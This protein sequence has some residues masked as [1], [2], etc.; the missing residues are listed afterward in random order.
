MVLEGDGK[1]DASVFRQEKVGGP[2][3]HTTAGRILFWTS[4]SR[5]EVGNGRFIDL[6]PMPAGPARRDDKSAT[7]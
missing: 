4:T 3:S 7:K 1:S 6:G 5:I 2:R